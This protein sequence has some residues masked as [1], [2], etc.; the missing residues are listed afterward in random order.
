MLQDKQVNLFE[1]KFFSFHEKEKVKRL[2]VLPW[3]MELKTEESFKTSSA[4]FPFQESDNSLI[5]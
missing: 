3:K 2:L 5:E 1:L 4:D